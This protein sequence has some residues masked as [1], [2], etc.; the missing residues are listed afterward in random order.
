VT[1]TAFDLADYLLRENRGGRSWR[2]IAREDYGDRVHFATLNRIALSGGGWL[3]RDR[4][5]LRVLG[6]VEA[7]K[8][9]KVE[10]AISKMARDTTNSV[11]KRKPSKKEY[12]L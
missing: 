2:T 8:R 11:L 7:R 12:F 5:V 1:C 6:L 10:K 9:T 3:P 4:R